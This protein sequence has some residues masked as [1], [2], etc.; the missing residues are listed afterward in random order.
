MRSAPLDRLPTLRNKVHHVTRKLRTHNRLEAVTHA[1][2]AGSS[3]RVI[4]RRTGVPQWLRQF[5]HGDVLQLT[6]GRRDI[7]QS[8]G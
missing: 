7:M 5:R 1:H 8:L 4:P 6:N 3:S 2:G